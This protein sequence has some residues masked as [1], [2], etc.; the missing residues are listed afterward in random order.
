LATSQLDA[1]QVKYF[2]LFKIVIPPFGFGGSVDSGI[3]LLDKLDGLST[4]PAVAAFSA[5]C[6]G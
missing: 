6:F 1:S 4:A 3:Y 2:L 5:T